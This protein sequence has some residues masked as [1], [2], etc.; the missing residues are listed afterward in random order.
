MGRISFARALIEIS[1]DRELK[2]ELVVVIHVLDETGYTK[3]TIIVEYEWKP[4]HCVDCKN[5][6][7]SHEHCRKR[8][9]E[10]EV[11]AMENQDDKFIE[12]SHDKETNKDEEMNIVK[13]KNHFDALS[14]HEAIFRETSG[15]TSGGNGVTYKH[16]NDRIVRRTLWHDLGLH[17]LVVRGKPWILMG[18]FNAALNLEDSYYGSYLMNNAMRDFKE[19]VENIE[20]LDINSPGLHYTWNQKPKSVNG[21]LKKL[22]R[23]IGNIGSS[24]EDGCNSTTNNNSIRS[25]LD[26]EKLNG[27][28]FLDWYRNLRIFLR[29]EQKLHHLEEALPKAPPATVTAVVRNAYTCRELKTMFQQQAEQE[30]FETVKAFHAC[31]Q[32]EGQYDYD[33]FVQNYNMHDMGKTILKLH[34]MLKLAEK[35]IPKKAHVVLAIRQELKKNKAS[36]SGISGIFTIELFSFPKSNTWIYDTGCGTHICN[37]IQGLRGYQKL[38]KGALDLYVGNGN[39]AAVEAIGSFKLILPSGM[40]LVLDNYHFPPFITRGVISL[41]CLWDKGFCHKFMDNGAILVSKDNIFYFIAFPHDGIFEIDMH[42]HISNERSIYT[43]SNK[44]TKHNLDSTFLWHC[45]LGH[46]NK[47]RITKLQHNGLLES[48]NDES[49]DICVS[50]IFG[51]MA[52]KPFTHV[53]ERADDLLGIIHSDGYALES[54]AR[55]L[56]MVPTKKVNKTPYEMWNEKVLNLSYLKNS[57]I[58]QEAS[59]STIDFDEIQR[60]DAQPSNNTSQHQPEVEHDDVDPQTDVIPVHRSARIPQAPERYGFYIDAEEHELGDYCEPPN[61]RAALSDPKFEKWLEAMNV[62]MQSMKNN[63]VW[64]LVDLPPNCN[65]VGSKWLFKKKTDMDGNIHTYKAR[66]VAKN[67]RDVK[68]AFLNGRLNEDVY[69]VQPEGF[70]NPK[71]PRR[72]DT[73]KRGTVPMQPNVAL[74]KSQ[75]PSTL[76]EETD[77]DDL[78]SQT[79]F[80]FV[81]NGGAV[82]WKSSKQSTTAMSSMEAEYIAAAEA[83]MEAIWICKLIYGLGVVP[84]IDKHMDIYCDNT[85]AITIA[86]EPGVKKDNNLADPFKKPMPCTKHSRS[87][88]LRPAGSFIYELDEVQKALDLNTL[89][90]EL[91]EEEAAY[92]QAFNRA[93]LDDSMVVQKL[94]SLKKPFRKLLRDQGNLHERVNRLRHELDEVQKALDLNTLSLE[95]R[96]EEAAYVQAFNR[97]SLDV[98]RFLK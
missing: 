24:E 76:A 37:T 39:S 21:I 33:Q 66:L 79:G 50:F 5:F 64:N 48:I 41:S 78:R 25:I 85:S 54:A 15:E 89:S 61:Y 59:R 46:I 27:S 18:D 75:G 4:P 34:A 14:Q 52:R 22:D 1:S 97:A 20:V 55:I 30:L 86:D 36:M 98:E 71:H 69:M 40:I 70:M 6:G 81:M 38:N 91:R 95:L 63:Q 65:T 3:E 16:G 58:S 88:G 31:K 87:I 83:A 19:C 74:S 44:K 10:P 11:V 92:V 80:V 51:K 29:N 9:K 47:K 23:I 49:F 96:E 43:C 72:M 45:R 73:S 94:K 13:L 90:L 82:D 35:S 93:S 32:E 62:E 68:T 17:K 7:H 84:R 12:K 42:N 60:E 26:K 28:N 77:R 67:L 56:N 57:L 2:E 8:V 53:S